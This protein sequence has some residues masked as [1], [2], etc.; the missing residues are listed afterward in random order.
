MKI[1]GYE[2]SNKDKR[3]DKVIN[4]FHSANCAER[5]DW[6]YW[7]NKCADYYYDKQLTPDMVAELQKAHMPTFTINRITPGIE[8]MKYFLTAN[9]PRWKTIGRDNSGF[10]TN[11]GAVHDALADY[12]WTQTS[13]GHS[14]YSQVVHDALVNQCGYFLVYVDKNADNGMGEAVVDFI[15]P[16]NVYRDKNSKDKY[17]RD[18]AYM[19]IAYNDSKSAIKQKLPQ[20]AKEI[21]SASGNIVSSVERPYW[22]SD[23]INE[24]E[25]SA[26]KITDGTEDEMIGYY[27][28]YS[29]LRV[30]FVTFER[31]VPPSQQE[32][33]QI[34]E[35]S[36]IR[37][38]EAEREINV[39]IQEVQKQLEEA[40]AKGEMIE[41]RAAFE[42]DKAKKEAQNKLQQMQQQA[43]EAVKQKILKTVEENVTEDEYNVLI[44]NEEFVKTIVPNTYNKYYNTRILV[45][46]VVGD[47]LLYNKI[48]P[49]ENYPIVPV[50]F[51]HTGSSYPLG[52]IKFALGKQQELNRA[53]QIMIHHAN[54]QSNPNTWARVGTIINKTKALEDKA[55]AGSIIEFAGE[56][57]PVDRPPAPL[58]N[59]FFTI[60]E[61]SKSDID[62]IL[63]VDPRMMGMANIGNEPFKTTALMDKIGT[64]RI[65]MFKNQILEPALELLGKVLLEISQNLYTAHK[66]WRITDPSAGN[67]NMQSKEF[68]IN[69]P[70]INELGKVI[71]KMF[72]Y[73]S[74]QYDIKIV[75]GSMWPTSEEAEEEKF[76]TW[77]KENFIDRK[78]AFENIDIKDK[79]GILKRIDERMMLQKENQG[80]EEQVKSIKGD[81]ETLHRQIVQMGIKLEQDQ[82]KNEMRKDVLETEAFETTIRGKLKNEVDA[83]IKEMRLIAKDFKSEKNLDKQKKN[84]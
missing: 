31:Q 70:V 18:A 82:A 52:A 13:D 62:F 47:K 48:L 80:L 10:D 71:G 6:V 19:L 37:L 65:Q 15:N 16:R 11:M 27:E 25:E 45:E 67:E 36:Q 84:K 54:L 35:M 20:Y 40:V 79:S 29:K 2:K 44:K 30:P 38:Q 53:H 41:D 51:I 43:V 78:A 33:Q 68:E 60:Q 1:F 34:K 26:T 4:L 56:T 21:E 63:G 66:V 14:V 23:N 39:K 3:A 32:M 69:K 57:P 46:C 22:A 72:D 28:C 77:W 9:K 58:N 8:V 59:A 64:R 50:P 24:I 49:I 74:T 75:S 7:T 55:T 83:I 76:Y 12:I 17:G 73:Q 81:N 61:E 42:L 5:Q